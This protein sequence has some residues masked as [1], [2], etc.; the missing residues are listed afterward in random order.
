[1]A[2]VAKTSNVPFA[3]PNWHTAENHPY[4]NESHRHLQ[5]FVRQYVD[6]EIIP[7][8]QE[9]EAQGAVAEKVTTTN[10]CE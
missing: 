3:D 1:M 4:Y 5:R 2:I 7:N 9:W 10:S 6:E 8:V